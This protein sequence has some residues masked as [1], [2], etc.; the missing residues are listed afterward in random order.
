MSDISKM[1]LDTDHKGVHQQFDFLASAM[2]VQVFANSDVFQRELLAMSQKNRDKWLKEQLEM[3]MIRFGHK[4][5]FLMRRLL[6]YV[7]Q[8]YEQFYS[9]FT[10]AIAF[11]P[12]VSLVDIQQTILPLAAAFLDN[13]F[14]REGL[15]DICLFLKQ[16]PRLSVGAR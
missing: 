16:D 15:A 3:A 5:G 8:L 14:N 4:P 6:L 13:Q 11:K 9:Q 10:Q 12:D 1:L 7:Y 2:Q